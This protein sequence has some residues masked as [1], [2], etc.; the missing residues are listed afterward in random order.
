MSQPPP[1]LSNLQLSP[2]PG[3]ERE[4]VPG[5]ASTQET[6]DPHD[7]VELTLV[8]R[9]KAELPDPSTSPR[10]T[11]DELAASYGADD[12]DVALVTQTLTALGV[13]VL[14][15]NPAARTMRVEGTVDLL[16]RVFGVALDVV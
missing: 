3:S 16:G 1:D 9:R 11:R 4:P 2:L 10:L 8:L 7:S 6:I 14:G 5:A 13:H 15:V 12:S